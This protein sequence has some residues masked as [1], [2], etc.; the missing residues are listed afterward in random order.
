MDFTEILAFQR[1][2]Q[3]AQHFKQRYT[4]HTATLLQLQ[5][6][7]VNWHFFATSHGKGAVD[8]VGGV[9][10]RAVNIAIRIR[11]Y[12]VTTGS[13][14][15]DCAKLLLD[16]ITVLYVPLEDV[17]A[18]KEFLDATW[19]DVKS[20]P[21]THDV[22]CVRSLGV[23]EIEYAVISEKPGDHFCLLPRSQFSPAAKQ[24][25][26]PASVSATSD[27]DVDDDSPPSDVK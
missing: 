27:C 25:A 12:H 5:G 3:L 20:L 8:G 13:D 22:H 11:K 9:V 4:F 6:L 19:Q 24:V 15:A 16:K 17:I 2:D 26:Q 23:G 18:Q 7:Q 21:G 1:L 14:Y 10:K